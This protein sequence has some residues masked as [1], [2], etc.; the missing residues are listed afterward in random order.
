VLAGLSE[1]RPLRLEA[2]L[3]RAA[4]RQFLSDYRMIGLQIRAVLAEA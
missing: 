1:G 3:T 4:A 2:G